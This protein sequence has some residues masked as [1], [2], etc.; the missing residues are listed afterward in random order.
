MRTSSINRIKQTTQRGFCASLLIAALAL[1][2]SG[3]AQATL[4]NLIPETPDIGSFNL[5]I[6]YVSGMLTAS[7]DAVTLDDDG[8][9]GLDLI[10]GGTFDLAA[11]ID[12]SET[13]RRVALS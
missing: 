13:C 3:P 7:G 1:G 9:G 5:Q 12:R 2:I 10:T 8:V 4:L 11:T 6:D